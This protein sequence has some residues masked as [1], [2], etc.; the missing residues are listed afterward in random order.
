MASCV[1]DWAYLRLCLYALWIPE[2]G[3]RSIICPRVTTPPPDLISADRM[4]VLSPMVGVGVED[5]PARST[6]RPTGTTQL[7][8]FIY[9]V[10]TLVVPKVVIDVHFDA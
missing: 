1:P 8:Y 10:I 4:H 6:D 5:S 7:L 9:E 2:R 3:R